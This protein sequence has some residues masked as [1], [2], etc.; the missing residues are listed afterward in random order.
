MSKSSCVT[1]STPPSNPTQHQD[2]GH[3][4]TSIGNPSVTT[5]LEEEQASE[6]DSEYEGDGEDSEGDESDTDGADI[7]AY[8]QE[9]TN[10]AHH[11]YEYEYEYE[12]M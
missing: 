2:Q 9:T 11:A 3:P 12:Y 5:E 8:K 6:N 4:N 7:P 1:G 10:Q